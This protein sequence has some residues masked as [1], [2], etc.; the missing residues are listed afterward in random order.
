MLSS[1]AIKAVSRPSDIFQQRDGPLVDWLGQIVATL[2][3]IDL[4]EIVER[5]GQFAFVIALLQARDHRLRERKRFGIFA[6]AHEC[7]D[8]RALRGGTDLPGESRR[9]K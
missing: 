2:A 8:P 4:T 6:G 9:S 3:G 1:G 5:G 7:I